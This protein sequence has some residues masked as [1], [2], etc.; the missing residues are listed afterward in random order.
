VSDLGAARPSSIRLTPLSAAEADALAA[1]HARLF[2]PGWPE[3]DFS[4]FLQDAAVFGVGAR[5]HSLHGFILCRAAVD[6]AEVLTFGVAAGDRRKGLG[7]KLL[8][9]AVRQA[10][11]RGARALFLEVGEDNLAARTLYGRTGFRCVG[12]REGY[13]TRQTAGRLASAA[14]LVLRYA[15][16]DVAP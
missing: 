4:Q 1:L 12:R 9:A 8:T 13:Y 15:L 3:A 14:A 7:R 2:P 11:A 16:C 10:R 5:G 6:E